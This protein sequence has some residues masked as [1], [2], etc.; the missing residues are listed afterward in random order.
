MKHYSV[1]LFFIIL[2]AGCSNPNTVLI[3]TEKQQERFDKIL[4]TWEGLQKDQSEIQ[5]ESWK[6]LNI[7]KQQQEQYAMQLLKNEQMIKEYSSQLQ[8]SNNNQ[9]EYSQKFKEIIENTT[10][11]LRNVEHHLF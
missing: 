6:Q 2:V 1:V 11:P 3:Q 9:Q 5:K 8:T 10:V 4:D 7:A